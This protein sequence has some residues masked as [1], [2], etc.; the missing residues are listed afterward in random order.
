MSAPDDAPAKLRNLGPKS[1]AWLRQVGL[2]SR[3]DLAEAGPVGAF[4]RIKRAGFKPGRNLLYSLEGALR[5]CHWRDV[6]EARRAE[7][8]E[9]AD[10]Q[11]AQLPSP[12]NQPPAAP[13]KTTH[14]TPQ[15]D[16]SG[17]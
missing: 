6:S 3:D 10:A 7:L 5:D 9:Q 8:V 1:V 12:R 4:V 2:H 11:I 13:V 16:D 15:D 14:M 17:D